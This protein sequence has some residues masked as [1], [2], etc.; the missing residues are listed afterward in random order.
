MLIVLAYLGSFVV[1]RAPESTL[2]VVL[3][4]IPTMAPFTMMLRIVMPPGPPVWQVVLSLV[5]LVATTAGVIW[6]AGRIF[7]IGLLMQGKPPT[8]PELVKWV[9]R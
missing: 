6:A 2:A 7:R 1:I 4:F 8:L 9:R 5:V 3:S